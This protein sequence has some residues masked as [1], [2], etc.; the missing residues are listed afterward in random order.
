MGISGD[1]G[2]SAFAKVYNDV[3]LEELGLRLLSRLKWN[4]VAMVEFKKV[5]EEGDYRLMEI[6]PRLWGSL[7]LSI[8]AGIDFPYLMAE[9]NRLPLNRVRQSKS[10]FF[11]LGIS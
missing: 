9:P 11:F 5:I 10:D 4:G 3:R 6:N 2:P 8:A 1:R 7:D